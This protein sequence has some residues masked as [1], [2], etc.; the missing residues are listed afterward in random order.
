MPRYSFKIDPLPPEDGYGWILRYFE[1]DWEI[2][3]YETFSAH[4]GISWMIQKEFENAKFTGELWVEEMTSDH[5]DTVGNQSL[6]EPGTEQMK[7]WF[8]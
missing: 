3:G 1:D 8:E 2:P 7:L 5:L 6:Y 4:R